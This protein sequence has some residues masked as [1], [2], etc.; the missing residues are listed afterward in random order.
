MISVAIVSYNSGRHLSQCLTSLTAALDGIDAEVLVYDNA[1]TDDSLLVLGDFPHVHVVAGETNIGFAKACNALAERSVG[2]YLLFLNPDTVIDQGAIQALMQATRRY[3]Q[4]GLYGAKTITRDG[5]EVPGSAQGKMTL[6]STFC[7]ASG[8]STVFKGSRL[9]DRETI[10]G[11][12]RCT[13]REVDVLSGGALLV[14]KSAWLALGGFDTRFFMY[15][16]D[17]DLCARA[18]ALGYAPVFVA[19]ARVQHEVGG[20]SSAGSGLVLLHRGK[21]TYLQKFWS[22]WKAAVG[23][24]LLLLG[25]GL[26]SWVARRGVSDRSGGAALGWQHAWSRRREW[27]EGW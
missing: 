8:L 27:R 24:R 6:W 21:V 18:W 17:A 7:F 23:I 9:V 1:S 10:P 25:V 5:N 2:D 26:R 13:D 4:A 20:S 16:E 12:D 19:G 3:P 14:S 15:A 22:P 11:W